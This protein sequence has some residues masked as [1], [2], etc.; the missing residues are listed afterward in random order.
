MRQKHVKKS[1]YTMINIDKLHEMILNNDN[2]DIIATHDGA[3]G[4]NRPGWVYLIKVNNHNVYRLFVDKKHEEMFLQCVQYAWNDENGREWYDESID[5]KS[6]GTK[7]TPD[8]AWYDHDVVLEYSD[9][10]WFKLLCTWV[11][12]CETDDPH[13]TIYE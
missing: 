6:V 13:F 11:D 4:F 2:F 10:A 12:E 7:Q 3:D 8:D 5:Y 9:N 1:V